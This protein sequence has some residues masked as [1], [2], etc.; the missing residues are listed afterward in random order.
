MF[1]RA[2]TYRIKMCHRFL[3]TT[4]KYF[5]SVYVYQKRIEEKLII[6]LRWTKNIIKKN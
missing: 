2:Y 4:I 1:M 3:K 5:N 6:E